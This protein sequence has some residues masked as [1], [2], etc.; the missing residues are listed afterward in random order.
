MRNASPRMGKNRRNP[1]CN[2]FD[3]VDRP[4]AHVLKR[5][6]QNDGLAEH[7]EHDRQDEGRAM[8]MPTL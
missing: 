1:T 4:A 7:A 8:I 5:P 6:V 3:Q 2:D